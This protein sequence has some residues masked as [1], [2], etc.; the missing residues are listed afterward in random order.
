MTLIQV[1]LDFWFCHMALCIWFSF[2]W[3][4]LDGP[5]YWYLWQLSNMAGQWSIWKSIS[6]CISPPGMLLQIQICLHH[7]FWDPLTNAHNR[8]RLPGGL[9]IFVS[10]QTRIEIKWKVVLIAKHIC[11]YCQ[12]FLSKCAQKVKVDR[13]LHLCLWVGSSRIEIKGE[14]GQ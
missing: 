4:F 11:P 5:S 7:L 6:G 1:T 2:V 3:P 9:H 14:V 13:G 8:S 10:V 12:I